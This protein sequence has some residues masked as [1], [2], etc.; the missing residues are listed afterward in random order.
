M[1]ASALALLVAVLVLAGCG[2]GGGGTTTPPATTT[3]PSNG[4]ASKPPDQVI[5]DAQ[6]AA[7]S[8]SSLHVSGQG[9][10]SGKPIDIDLSLV[11]GKGATG[12]I[13]I[14]GL[15]VDIV[16]IGKRVYIKG[17][18]AFYKHFAGTAAA[19]LLK[20]KWL[21]GPVNS[22]QLKPL[23]ALATP[24]SLFKNLS[25]KNGK[26][27]NKGATT[28]NG[29]QVVE[30]RDPK[31]NGSLYVAATG[32]PYPLAVVERK[33]GSG[34][35]IAFTNWNAHVTLKAPPGAIDI[36]QFGGGLP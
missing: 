1:R 34:G 29:Q 11:R 6:K 31:K 19:E 21:T 10:D 3:V 5:A 8:A 36:S 25:T 7:D 32:N 9:L 24:A 26:L 27:V 33:K 15:E 20:G 18:Q 17:S 2:G 4:E 23:A 22:G 12:S 16:V 14:S 13:K 35:T 28:Y 30:L